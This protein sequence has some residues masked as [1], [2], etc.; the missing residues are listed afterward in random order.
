M[1]IKMLAAIVAVIS[2]VS[3]SS[4]TKCKVC[5]RENSPEVRICEKDYSSQTEY[6]FAVD[7]AEAG[8]YTCKES[9]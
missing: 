6:G 1:K 9:L 5:T 3:F 2:L 4:C 8:G 7:A